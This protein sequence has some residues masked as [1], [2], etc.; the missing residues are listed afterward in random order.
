VQLPEVSGPTVAAS[1]AALSSFLIMLTQRRNLQESIRPE[2]VLLDWSRRAQGEEECEDDQAPLDLIDIRT[3]QNVGRGAAHRIE[4]EA[5]ADDRGQPTALLLL[6]SL[7]VLGADKCYSICS[8]IPIPWQNVKNPQQDTLTITVGLSCEDSRE[9]RYRTEYRICAIQHDASTF[10]VGG[11]MV[12]PGVVLSRRSTRVTPA[13]RIR[14][15]HWLAR[16]PLL[17]RWWAGS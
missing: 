14:M 16:V 8:R 3:L 10:V 12:A 6:L 11:L 13:C 9:W 15:R 1:F 5:Y 2:L 7:P 17:G 4:I